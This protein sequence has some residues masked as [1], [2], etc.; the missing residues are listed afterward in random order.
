MTTEYRCNDLGEFATEYD[1]N[2]DRLQSNLTVNPL[3][4]GLEYSFQDSGKV[5]ST[6]NKTTSTE[7][8]VSPAL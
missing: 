6:H 8:F 1:D 4:L 5:K 7:P 3:M 2:R